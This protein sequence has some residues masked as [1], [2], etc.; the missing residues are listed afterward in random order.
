LR[1]NVRRTT[2]ALTVGLVVFL[3]SC[4]SLDG[5][6]EP[7]LS[8]VHHGILE[9]FAPGYSA[10]NGKPDDKTGTL[11]DGVLKPLWAAYHTMLKG[12]LVRSPLAISYMT[13]PKEKM[14][15]RASAVRPRTCSGDM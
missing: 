10:A 1:R 7:A 15:L 5:S 12:R 13:A 9:C 2:A 14:S 3:G 6:L 4:T 11:L 8:I